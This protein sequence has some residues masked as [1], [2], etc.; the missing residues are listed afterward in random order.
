MV[1]QQSQGKP[2]IRSLGCTPW[3]GE[4]FKNYLTRNS[5]ARLD[6]PPAETAAETAVD[7]EEREKQSETA[8]MGEGG[9][10]DTTRKIGI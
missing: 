9:M 3:R 1:I 7:A 2:R 10:T 8:G 5:P 6:D 4:I